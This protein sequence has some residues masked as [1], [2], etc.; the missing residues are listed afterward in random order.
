MAQRSFKRFAS[1]NLSLEDE[2]RLGQPQ[3]WDSEAT[4]EA[5]EQQTSTSTGRLSDTLGPSKSTTHRHLT[6]LGNIYNSCRILPHELT[7]EQAQRRVEFCRKL[8]QLP[9]DYRFIKRIVTC[10]E[11]FIYLN[12][13]DLQ[14]QWL[15]KDNCQCRWQRESASKKKGSLRLVELRRSYLL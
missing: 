11:K 12:N 8:L 5:T 14:K 10:D 4:K 3:I 2:Q 13:P 6:A 9:K 7:A 1:G 15:V